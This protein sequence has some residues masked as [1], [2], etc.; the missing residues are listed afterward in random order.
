MMISLRSFRQTF[1]KPCA[2]SRPLVPA[3]LVSSKLPLHN[4]SDKST[5]LLTSTNDQHVHILFSMIRH[6]ERLYA[7][8][9]QA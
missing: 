2:T 3:S 9:V 7:V 6:P 4:L 1:F 8:T 5:V